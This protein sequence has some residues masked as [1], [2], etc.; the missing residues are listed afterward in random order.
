MRKKK[1][2]FIPAISYRDIARARQAQPAKIAF[3]VWENGYKK[4]EGKRGEK[5]NKT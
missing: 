1:N 5:T 2:N 4:K 3:Q